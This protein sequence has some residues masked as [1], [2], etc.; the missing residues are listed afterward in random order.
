MIPLLP[1]DTNGLNAA[2]DINDTNDAT[3][4]SVVKNGLLILRSMKL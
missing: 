4:P 2:N 3:N 1:I